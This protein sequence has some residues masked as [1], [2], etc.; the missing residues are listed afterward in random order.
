MDI[1]NYKNQHLTIQHLTTQHLLLSLKNISQRFGS[2]ALVTGIALACS[3]N[4]PPPQDKHN[5]DNDE[6]T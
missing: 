1:H 3:D 6:C 2:A 5:C 4:P